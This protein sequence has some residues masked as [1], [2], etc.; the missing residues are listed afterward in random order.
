MS[1]ISQSQKK[2]FVFQGRHPTNV[3]LPISPDASAYSN[4]P[5]HFEVVDQ[6]V[7]FAQ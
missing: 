7:D 2:I 4:N 5:K 1:P 3:S 6:I